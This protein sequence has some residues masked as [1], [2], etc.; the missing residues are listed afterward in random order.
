MIFWKAV[1]ACMIGFSTLAKAGVA[2]DYTM[3][4]ASNFSGMTSQK[5]NNQD[6]F[7]AYQIFLDAEKN[8]NVICML[9][10]RESI[11]ENIF[12]LQDSQYLLFMKNLGLELTSRDQKN[13]DDEQMIDPVQNLLK[14]LQEKWF[15]LYIFQATGST[16]MSTFTTLAASSAAATVATIY[17]FKTKGAL[18]QGMLKAW[19]ILLFDIL[20]DKVLLTRIL[21]IIGINAS[22]ASGRLS[23][24]DK[25]VPLAP[26]EILKMK[27]SQYWS[28]T[29]YMMIRDVI[30]Y[31]ASTTVGVIAA[32]KLSKSTGEALTQAKNILLKNSPAPVQKYIFKAMSSYVGKLKPYL[33]IVTKVSGSTPV[34]FVISYV[35]SDIALSQA[36]KGVNNIAEMIS[37]RKIKQLE[38]TYLHNSEKL[39]E[40]QF[41]NAV[42]E[43]VSALQWYAAVRSKVAIDALTEAESDFMEDYACNSIQ[44]INS[45]PYFTREA[46]RQRYLNN[47]YHEIKSSLKTW[48][49]NRRDNI[50]MLAQTIRNLNSF[51]RSYLNGFISRLEG[52]KTMY[53]MASDPVY[54]YNSIYQRVSNRLGYDFMQPQYSDSV[55]DEVMTKMSCPTLAPTTPFEI[56]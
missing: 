31:S 48:D 25:I 27:S 28:Q 5:C 52:A 35:I 44:G 56:Y 15:D 53:E 54:Q 36:E 46:K 16:R 3:L 9:T 50:K 33:K 42:E 24:H 14:G 23:V 10:A 40:I 18:S 7:A 37:E 1:L 2:N 19:R 4:L 32:D 8:E 38:T 11:I 34:S 39:S 6:P 47:L 30:T 43:H 13:T 55:E 20:Q 22:H 17:L 51:N 49:T 29:E 26:F 12:Q 21:A 45:I 41:L